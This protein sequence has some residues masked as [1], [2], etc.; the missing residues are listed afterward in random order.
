M[1][2]ARA[3]AVF[4]TT[5]ITNLDDCRTECEISDH[6]SI[7]ALVYEG[8]DGW[9]VNSLRPVG[10]DE[11]EDFDASIVEAKKRLVHYV[12]R[13]GADPPEGLT[14]GGLSLWL[15]QKDDGSAMGRPCDNEDASA[16]AVQV[17]SEIQ[18]RVRSLAQEGQQIEAIREIRMATNCS[19][20][21]AKAWLRDNC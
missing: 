19:L 7:V 3:F 15:M 13:L 4:S 8:H 17:P 14:L 9:H 18:S 21:E 11:R 2:Q 20:V 12:N 6:S 10:T 16:P 5:I 1:I